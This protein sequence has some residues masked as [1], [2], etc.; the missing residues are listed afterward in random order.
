MRTP[1]RIGVHEWHIISDANIVLFLKSPYSMSYCDISFFYHQTPLWL[2][3]KI[4]IL[5]K[6]ITCLTY[7]I[8]TMKVI[9]KYVRLISDWLVNRINLRVEVC[10]HRSICLFFCFWFLFLHTVCA[11]RNN[12]HHQHLL[13]KQGQQVYT[14]VCM[15]ALRGMCA[16]TVGYYVAILAHNVYTEH[17]VLNIIMWM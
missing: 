8:E 17:T 13:R 3:N 2:V 16:W 5:V 10:W 7:Y 12:I 9:I 1:S 15:S 11:Q 6:I 4:F 14:A